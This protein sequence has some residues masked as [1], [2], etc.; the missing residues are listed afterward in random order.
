MSADEPSAKSFAVHLRANS[1]TGCPV[2][3]ALARTAAGESA[4]S[5]GTTTHV[6]II[7]EKAS[8]RWDVIAATLERAS[9]SARGSG[10]VRR[11]HA[12]ER[13]CRRRFR[14]HAGCHECDGGLYQRLQL[15]G[16]Q[17]R[18]RIQL[19]AIISFDASPAQTASRDCITPVSGPTF[20]RPNGS[21]PAAR[22][23]T[24]HGLSRRLDRVVFT[25]DNGSILPHLRHDGEHQRQS[26]S[27][28]R[29]SAGGRLGT[30][31]T[32]IPFARDALTF[33]SYR[34]GGGA[35]S[36]HPHPHA[37]DRRLYNSPVIAARWHGPS[38]GSVWHPDGSGT[39]QFWRTTV[40]QSD[41]TT[42]AAATAV[43]TNPTER[44]VCR[45]T[46]ATC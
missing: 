35:A 4:T 9:R 16:D 38:H 14:H 5:K 2:I 3:I 19:P 17:L 24:P 12:V 28:A 21:G 8:W 15:L 11:P 10:P 25:L 29:R 42:E 36:G 6:E 40:L 1:T 13:S 39:H 20:T 33:A 31:V 7:Y 46:R 27:L 18:C 41:A 32:Y 43:C 26:T 30:D 22:R 45:R 44:G 23:C 34:A 37:T